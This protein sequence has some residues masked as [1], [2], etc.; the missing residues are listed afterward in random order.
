MKEGEGTVED[1]AFF[2][3]LAISQKRAVLLRAG[4]R[5][6]KGASPECSSAISR[7]EKV[8]GQPLKFLL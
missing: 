6:G 7:E 2:T 8:T 1:W 5:E 4:K 3:A